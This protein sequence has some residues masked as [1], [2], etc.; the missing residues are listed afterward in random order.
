MP[1][2]ILPQ[3][4]LGKGRRSNAMGWR[5]PAAACAV[6]CAVGFLAT[7]GVLRSGGVAP[8]ELGR[9]RLQSSLAP[10]CFEGTS[11]KHGEVVDRR[12]VHGALFGATQPWTTAGGPEKSLLL[13]NRPPPGVKQHTFKRRL[14]SSER[15]EA[16][17]RNA[18]LEFAERRRRLAEGEDGPFPAFCKEVDVAIVGGGDKRCLLLA[19][20]NSKALPYHVL[21]YART[22]EARAW[23][24]KKRGDPKTELP[25]PQLRSRAMGL[26]TEFYKQYDATA[27]ALDKVLAG[28][29]WPKHETA[30]KHGNLQRYHTGRRGRRALLGGRRGGGAPAGGHRRVLMTAVNAYDVDLALNFVASAKRKRIPID[31]LVVVCADAPSAE[32]LRAVGVAVFHHAGLGFDQNVNS[33][34]KRAHG[35]FGDRAFVDMMWF[36]IAP[37]YVANMLGYD[38]LFMDADVVWFGDPWEALY[39]HDAD[40]VWMDDGA[41]TP[42]FA[43]FFANTGFFLLKSTWRSETLMA[44]LL[45]SYDVVVAWQ[46]HQAVTNQFLAE[47]HSQAGLS[48]DVLDTNRFV[49][50]AFKLN[51]KRHLANDPDAKDGPLVFH[52]NFTNDKQA[53]IDALK[54]L[55]LW[56]LPAS[57]H[58]AALIANPHLATNCLDSALRA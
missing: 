3:R 10:K 49:P 1:G 44:Q 28:V 31:N 56:F 57:C 53:K 33:D 40:S 25:G 19:Q 21:R 16:A 35:A 43:P 15:S 51:L 4:D 11:F 17:G 45:I 7:V 41:R 37:L 5:R 39:A 34:A 20:T 18:T 32:A 58:V 50:G 47:A 24:L 46:S 13:F 27:S 29:A 9:R 42:R 55:G 30:G 48:I 2:L 23:A 52:I 38:V 26:L 6:G 14:S 12:E 54:S 22:G 36:K 8:L